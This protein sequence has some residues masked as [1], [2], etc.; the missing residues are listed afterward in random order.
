MRFRLRKR[1]LIFQSLNCF[2]TTLTYQ[3]II[4]TKDMKLK[5]ESQSTWRQEV[6]YVFKGKKFSIKSMSHLIDRP[7]L[8]WN[9][10]INLSTKLK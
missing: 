7:E 2:P 9:L 1:G 3:N 8:W 5:E 10:L 6:R 4:Q